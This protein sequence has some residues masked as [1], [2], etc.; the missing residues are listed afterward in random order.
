MV[1]DCWPQCVAPVGSGAVERVMSKSAGF[2]LVETERLVVNR[3]GIKY[4]YLLIVVLLG[5]AEGA[6]EEAQKAVHGAGVEHVHAD[7]GL[8]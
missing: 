5:A 6:V 4:V 1:K 3:N 8:G 7:R 2:S